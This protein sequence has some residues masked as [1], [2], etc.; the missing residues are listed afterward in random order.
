MG[1]KTKKHVVVRL[2]QFFFLGVVMGVTEDLLA[3]HFSTDAKITPH[4]FKV[5]LIIAV[6]F[7]FIS[8]LLADSGIFRRLIKNNRK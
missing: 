6:P 1:P 8:E 3:I 4:V 5:A 2:V 7:A